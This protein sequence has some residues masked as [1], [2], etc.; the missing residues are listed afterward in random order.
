MFCKTV[1]DQFWVALA[2]HNVRASKKESVEAP[3]QKML[4][5]KN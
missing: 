5:G 3:I 2:F 1:G 4:V